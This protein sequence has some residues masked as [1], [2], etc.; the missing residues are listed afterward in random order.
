MGRALLVLLAAA[1]A[2]GAPAVKW[3]PQSS[4]VTARFRGVSAVSDRIAWASGSRGTV[5]RTTDGGAT[6]QVRPVAG[7][8]KLDF[9]DVDAMSDAVAYVLSIGSGETSRI[10][11]TDDGGA[12]W[13]LQ[14]ANTDPK[15]FLDAMTFADPRHGYA[16]SDS[17]DGRFVVLSTANGGRSWN[18][19]PAERLPPALDGEGA[20]AGSGTNIAT[21]GGDRIWIGTTAS[22]VLRSLDGGR[23]WTAVQTPLAHNASTGI[24]SVAFRDATHGVVVGGNYSKEAEAV[25]N[26]AFT[27]DGGATWTLVRE[28]GLS[29]F[30][31]AVAYVPGMKSTLVAVGPSG[32]DL[33]QDGG[34]TWTAIECA[35]FHAFSFAPR[36]AIGWGAGE[37]GRL[38]RFLYTP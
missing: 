35:G 10:Y 30:R 37:G 17:V 14:F 2:V 21:D 1:F 12:S 36:R 7:A 13:T 26:V 38:S 31:S 5:V 6:W 9:R 23:T 4:G 20:F 25:D 8:E 34:R 22:R 11:K 28:H 29:G 27:A 15:V 3:E 33:S 18:R 19:I 32:A 24:F 16:F